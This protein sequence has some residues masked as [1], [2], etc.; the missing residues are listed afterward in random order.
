MKV[1]IANV[2]AA[3]NTNKSITN[4]NIPMMPPL[5][6]SLLPV[7]EVIL[8]CRRTAFGRCFARAF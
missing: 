1:R 2:M 8:F 7:L 3:P 4:I 6:F 5:P